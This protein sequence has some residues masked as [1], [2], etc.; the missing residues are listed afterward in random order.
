MGTAGRRRMV[1][2][3]KRCNLLIISMTNLDFEASLKQVFLLLH[4]GML[5]GAAAFLYFDQTRT[6]IFF[7]ASSTI[8]LLYYVMY[9]NNELHTR[10]QAHLNLIEEAVNNS[11]GFR[12]G[13]TQKQSKH[14]KSLEER[15]QE[16]NTE[17]AT[18]LIA[19]E[20]EN[21]EENDSALN[22]LEK[23][24]QAEEAG[25]DRMGVKN[26]ILEKRLEKKESGEQE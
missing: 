11:K 25:K 22:F 14:Q 16:T 10:L 1:K 6:A 19:T 17:E 5:G 21:F 24:Q 7:A 3:L 12:E 2:G 4:V 26:F 23:A 18:E 20:M 15:L 8:S 9:Q 13:V